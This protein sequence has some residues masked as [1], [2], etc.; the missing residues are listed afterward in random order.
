MIRANTHLSL[1]CLQLTDSQTGKLLLRM[2]SRGWYRNLQSRL[3]DTWE[4]SSK[5]KRIRSCHIRNRNHSLENIRRN[6]IRNLHNPNFRN[7][8]K[9]KLACDAICAIPLDGVKDCVLDF[10]SDV[11]YGR[12]QDDFRSEDGVHSFRVGSAGESLTPLRRVNVGVP[13]MSRHV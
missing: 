2:V 8:L 3:Q 1:C 10:L 12:G 7:R 13:L 9:S 6:R 5:A 11:V 4:R